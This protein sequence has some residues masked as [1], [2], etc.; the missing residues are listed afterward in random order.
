[1]YLDQVPDNDMGY[2]LAEEYGF[3]VYPTVAE[4]LRCGGDRLA[5]DGIALVAEHGEYPSNE[6]GQQLY[7]RH[8]LFMQLIDVMKQDGVVCPIFVDKH[9]SYSWEKASAHV[10]DSERNGNPVDGGVHRVVD[11]ALSSAGAGLHPGTRT[12]PDRWI[13]SYRRSRFSHSGSPAGDRRKAYGR[14]NRRRVGPGF[15]GKQGLGAA[16][17]GSLV[18]GIVRGGPGSHGDSQGRGPRKT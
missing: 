3:K 18:T 4:A 11:V 5:V 7:P 9:F 14:G 13:R 2:D 6:K 8:E 15:S 17:S 1:M 10:R 12:S 16:R